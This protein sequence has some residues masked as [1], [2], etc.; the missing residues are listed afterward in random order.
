MFRFCTTTN[1][2]ILFLSHSAE[3]NDP[4]LMLLYVDHLAL[5]AHQAGDYDRAEQLFRRN[6]A[7]LEER[8]ED[9]DD[10]DVRPPS[11]IIVELSLKET[12]LIY[13]FSPRDASA[14]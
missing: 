14:L 2:S 6:L 9:E 8:G 4:P 13:I 3:L 7:S 11:L 12:L 1:N 10:G 5:V